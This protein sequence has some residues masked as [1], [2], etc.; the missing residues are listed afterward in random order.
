MKPIN[1]LPSAQ[2]INGEVRCFDIVV[3]IGSCDY[4]YL[5]G[6]VNAVEK[7]GSEEHESG[8]L[9][10]DVFVDFQFEEYS[11]KRKREIETHFAR[12]SGTH[13]P[14]EELPLDN[15]IM[16]P[17]TLIRI[18]GS[19][20]YKFLES[21]KAAEIYCKAVMESVRGKAPDKKSPSREAR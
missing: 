14:F 8:N 6:E 20:Y 7:L 12:L 15:V 21:R 13:K 2:T 4:P 9:T 18:D 1:E 3:S 11:D 16:S 19:E 17:D 5:V 10:D